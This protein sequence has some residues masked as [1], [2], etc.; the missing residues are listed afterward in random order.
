MVVTVQAFCEVEVYMI[1]PYQYINNKTI[2]G[3][4]YWHDENEYTNETT[5]N[6]GVLYDNNVY[7]ILNDI[8]L[9]TELYETETIG[10]RLIVRK[11]KNRN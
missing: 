1:Q 10:K 5:H 8:D 7:E 2:I 9:I 4:R 11:L 3:V 6:I